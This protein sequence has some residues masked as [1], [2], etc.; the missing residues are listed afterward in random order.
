MD[1]FKTCIKHVRNLLEFGR[2]CKDLL[3]FRWIWTQLKNF[4]A[5][6][7][8]LT[9]FAKSSRILAN[10]CQSLQSCNPPTPRV[11]PAERIIF[12]FPTQDGW[13]NQL[14]ANI[15]LTS[16]WL[17]SWAGPWRFWSPTWPQLGSIFEPCWNHFGPFLG[18]ALASQLKTAL[19][20]ELARFLID[21]RTPRWPK[22]WKNH[23]FLWVKSRTRVFMSCSLLR[24]ILDRFW[25][26][27]GNQNRPYTDQKIRSERYPASCSFL[28]A[29]Q[30]LQKSMF[31]PTWPQLDP[32]EAAKK[33]PRAGPKR[34]ENGS[35]TVQNQCW[36]RGRFRSQSWT[37]FGPIWDRFGTV[38][39]S[40]WE[41]FSIGFWSI[42][43]RG[44]P[45]SVICIYACVHIC[46]YAEMHAYTNEMHNFIRAWWE[47]HAK[48]GGAGDS[49][50][51]RLR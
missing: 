50:R 16:S 41:R 20:H 40:I 4:I 10:L 28:K 2:I 29:I 25:D 12:A 39:G 5:F 8:K 34:S 32:W 6:L 42:F 3:T 22:I 49:P 48:R 38:L 46:N 11:I 45:I 30:D 44:T 43:G 21:F 15:F 31:G 1:S 36:Q 9:L 37:D 27:F 18:V 26:D 23:W 13:K 17:R 7:R 24:P 33:P 35:K 51:G 19:R 14:F 47:L